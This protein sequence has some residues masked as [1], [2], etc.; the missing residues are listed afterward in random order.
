MKIAHDLEGWALIILAATFGARAV[1][2][3]ATAR[4]AGERLRAVLARKWPGLY[5]AVLLFAVGVL[6][7]RYPQQRPWWWWI[8]VVALVPALLMLALPGIMSRRRAGLPWWRVGARVP[9]PSPSPAG[10]TGPAGTPGPGMLDL[11]EKIKNAK[12]STTRLS[13]GYD[14]EEV[15]V[16]LDK[17]IAALSE[18]RQ[19]TEAWLLNARFSATRL[20][21]GYVMQDVDSFLDEVAQTASS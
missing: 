1:G 14:E 19:V 16:F 2:E 9:S 12:F 17:L 18:G 10:F 7:L 15:D 4:R 8:Y 11:I 13:P 5:S 21:P 6:H 3:V 20:R